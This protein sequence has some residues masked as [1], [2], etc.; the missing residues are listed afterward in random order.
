MTSTFPH[1]VFVGM[2][3][4]KID[5]DIY[6]LENLGIKGDDSAGSLF[7]VPLERF[8]SIVKCSINLLV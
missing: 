1:F 3:K 2:G 6:W 5:E 4:V 8:F 7:P